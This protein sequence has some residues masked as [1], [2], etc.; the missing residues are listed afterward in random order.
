MGF[1]YL[2]NRKSRVTL[3]SRKTG[4]VPTQLRFNSDLT[5]V[6]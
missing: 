5:K 4:P 3:V 6:I 2:C 1:S